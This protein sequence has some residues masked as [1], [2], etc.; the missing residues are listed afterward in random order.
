MRAAHR[1]LDDLVD[2]RDFE[3]VRSRELQ[4]RRG[5][6]LL[7]RVAPQDRRAAFGRNH[8]VDGEFLHQHAIADRDSQ[9]AAAAALPC[10]QDDDWRVEQHHLA[11]VYGDGFGHAALLRLHAGERRGRVDEHEDR[12]REF[13]GEPHGAKR[14]AV[15]LRPRVSEV[16][17]D[18]VLRVAALH[19]AYEQHGVAL[20]LGETGHDRVVVGKAAIAVDLDKVGEQQLDEIIEART[21][22]MASDLDALPRG[23]R[24]VEIS[25]DDVDATPECVHLPLTGVGARQLVERVD[26]LEQRGDR[27]LEFEDFR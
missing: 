1:F 24:R 19:V 25:P 21:L 3:Q 26:L 20:V 16:A 11:Q 6:D 9:C 5:L 12:S 17:E 23:Q 14:L 22:R 15:A 8:A 10:D 27:F 2:D 7:R 4:R 13:L 18:F